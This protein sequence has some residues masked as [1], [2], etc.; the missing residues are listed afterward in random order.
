MRYICLVLVLIF[1]MSCK[2]SKPKVE[3]PPQQQTFAVKSISSSERNNYCIKEDIVIV[4]TE[5]PDLE[6][7]KTNNKDEKCSNKNIQISKNNFESC[8][9]T[10]SLYKG[11]KLIVKHDPFEY[12]STYSVKL[13]SNIKSKKNKTLKEIATKFKTQ[14]KY[15]GT[16]EHNSPPAFKLEKI[17]VEKSDEILSLHFDFSNKVDKN[18]LTFQDADG[19]CS[20]NIQVSN[21]N[22]TNCLA[23]QSLLSVPGAND[24]Q[25]T[26]QT[27]DLLSLDNSI[28]IKVKSEIRNV[29]VIDSVTS[30]KLPKEYIYSLPRYY[31]YMDWKDLGYKESLHTDDNKIFLNKEDIK[32]VFQF[33]EPSKPNKKLKRY[34]YE[35][36]D[37]DSINIYAPNVFYILLSVDK[38]DDVI[39]PSYCNSK[40]EASGDP[41]FKFKIECSLDEMN[42]PSDY[43]TTKE[44]GRSFLFSPNAGQSIFDQNWNFDQTLSY[45]SYAAKYISNEDKQKSAYSSECAFISEKAEVAKRIGGLALD[46]HI[47][48]IDGEKIGNICHDYGG[49]VYLTDWN[50]WGD[51][52][53]A[54]GEFLLRPIFYSKYKFLE[55]LKQDNKLGDKKH[56][57]KYI[58]DIKEITGKD[59]K[60]P[61]YYESQVIWGNGGYHWPENA[62]NKVGRVWQFIANPI[63]ISVKSSKNF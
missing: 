25:F 11:N 2:S 5:D 30:E 12:N 20:S 31:W 49:K 53:A 52:Y 42:L 46:A 58:K 55:K 13:T 10:E 38:I 4:F 62:M 60:I 26:L 51:D 35:Q 1:I 9:K 23:L 22:F 43:Y 41:W 45:S 59:A 57:E 19:D 50:Q 33:S 29:S 27:K 6:T 56:I 44:I 14:K 54:I 15:A 37:F 48:I 63:K 7:I 32:E 24:K 8:I 61:V 40:L 18:T 28:S 17:A 3:Q 47:E 16:S 39:L 34:Y 36:I 21:N